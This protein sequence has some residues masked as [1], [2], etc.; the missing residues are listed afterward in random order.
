METKRC[1]RRDHQ[2]DNPLPL[3]EFYVNRAAKDGLLS[4][5]KACQRRAM[6]LAQPSNT[7]Y[8]R[9]RHHRFRAQVFG[10]YGEVCRCCGATSRLTIDHV[11][12]NGAEHRTELFGPPGSQHAERFYRWIVASGYPGDL[13]VLCVACNTSKGTGPSCR[14]RHA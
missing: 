2:G 1:T 6:K 4:R 11:D 13:Q 10:H 14:L 7:R 5:C 3:S 9:E 12:G 8:H